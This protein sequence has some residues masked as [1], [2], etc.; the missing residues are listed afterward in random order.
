MKEVQRRRSKYRV[1][2]NSIGE[3]SIIWAIYDFSF[4]IMW[5]DCL[6]NL[7]FNNP[8][9]AYFYLIENVKEGEI[10]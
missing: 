6:N 8:L 9:D 1:Y 3:Y 2:Q 5:E 10:V 4:L 7:S